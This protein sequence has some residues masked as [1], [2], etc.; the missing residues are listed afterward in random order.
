MWKSEKD[1]TKKK[2]KLQANNP[3]EYRSKILN[4][5][6]ACQ[7]QLYFSLFMAE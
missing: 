4:N 5:I 1:I 6:L 2:G 3:D 7:I